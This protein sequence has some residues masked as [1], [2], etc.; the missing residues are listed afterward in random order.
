MP[1]F[2]AALPVVV[3]VA[4]ESATSAREM[5]ELAS[6]ALLSVVLAGVSIA[7]R[8]VVPRSGAKL[9]R[10]GERDDHDDRDAGVSGPKPP[11]RS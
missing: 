3:A 5:P 2:A 1:S 9:P 10:P 6:M 7:V 8:R 4:T 11:A